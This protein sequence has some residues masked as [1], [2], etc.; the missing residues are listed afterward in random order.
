MDR[1]LLGIIIIALVISTA[2]FVLFV[3]EKPEEPIEIL[4][5]GWNLPTV[6]SGYRIPNEE[7]RYAYSLGLVA[8]KPIERLE[9]IFLC[10]EN[11]TSL[12]PQTNRSQNISW[13]DLFLEIPELNS[14]ISSMENYPHVRNRTIETEFEI[15]GQGANYQGMVHDLTD[16]HRVIAPNPVARTLHTAHVFLKPKGEGGGFQYFRGSRDFFL[17]RNRS[18]IDI[19]VQ[20]N[21]NLTRFSQRVSEQGTS[22]RMEKAPP[23]GELIFD[24]LEKEDQIFISFA[25][26]PAMVPTRKSMLHLVLI[27]TNG[28]YQ[29]S[30]PSFLS[31]EGV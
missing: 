12:L 26:N 31:S 11:K 27:F 4:K 14:M 22:I 24:G 20:R 23:V 28:E 2:A 13:S 15:L 3:G 18:I 19:T 25:I 5:H 7:G 16:P 1:R 21:E 6:Q 8:R 9:I 10:L 29:T 30:L 17:H